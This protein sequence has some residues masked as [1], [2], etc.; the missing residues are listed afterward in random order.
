MRSTTT[1]SEK[2]QADR[3]S[4]SVADRISTPAPT[5][6]ASRSPAG[7]TSVTNRSKPSSPHTVTRADAAELRLVG[8]DR[9]T[10]AARQDD[11][12]ELRFLEIEVHGARVRIEAT[13]GNDRV[14]H[15]E[16]AHEFDCRR[17][18]GGA[19]VAAQFATGHI[20]GVVVH[21]RKRPRDI[22]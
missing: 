18:E 11:A 22:G 16:P 9:R 8:N 12:R 7:G 5:S 15:P 20:D 13:N 14:A 19:I 10:F 6:A 4:P 1:V 3:R 2:N 21:R 17:T